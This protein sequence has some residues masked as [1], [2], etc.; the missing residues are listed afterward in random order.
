[1]PHFGEWPGKDYFKMSWRDHDSDVVNEAPP[2]LNNWYP[3]FDAEDVSLIWCVVRQQ[4]DETAAKDIEVRWTIDG[5]VYFTSD[6]LAHNSLE[7]IYRDHMP[8]LG[9]TFG[10]TASAAAQNAALRVD[11]GGQS[12]KV[13]VRITSALG[14]NQ[15]LTCWC[16]RETLEQ[17]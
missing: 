15:V 2:I 9:G 10:L 12:F 13:E 7:Y 8:S 17:T 14:T 3:L 16:V 6:S 4:N 11:K 1:M 5:N